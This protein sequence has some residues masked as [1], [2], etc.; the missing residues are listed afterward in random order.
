MTNIKNL[1]FGE[2]LKKLRK[3]YRMTQDE[4]GQIV[5]VTK[6]Q[7]SLYERGN[8]IPS[9]EFLIKLIEYFN[10]P[11]EQL[12]YL[13]NRSPFSPLYTELV[14]SEEERVLQYILNSNQ[15]EEFFAKAGLIPFDF[16]LLLKESSFP[17]NSKSAINFL[18]LESNSVGPLTQYFESC[19][20]S[21]PVI[22]EKDTFLMNPYIDVSTNNIEGYPLLVELFD[23]LNKSSLLGNKVARLSDNNN[24]LA[25]KLGNNKI[26]RLFISSKATGCKLHAVY[27]PIIERDIKVWFSLDKETRQKI[28]YAY[29]INGYKATA[30]VKIAE[31]NEILKRKKEVEQTFKNL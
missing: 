10:C 27:S 13:K 20:E 16:K 19:F 17:Y 25:L 4:L 30:E 6:S 5:G 26:I 29:Y 1:Q 7:I 12:L 15:K 18:L 23:I 24:I 22:S 21:L 31:E 11:I 14:L 3:L 8:S 2:N 9:L 28:A